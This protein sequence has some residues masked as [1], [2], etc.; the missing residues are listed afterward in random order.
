MRAAARPGFGHSGA[1]DGA[2]IDS[3]ARTDGRR[4]G[5]RADARAR[6]ARGAFCATSVLDVD[7]QAGAATPI[8][9]AAD[10]DYGDCETAS[11]YYLRVVAT[12]GANAGAALTIDKAP[13]G[14]IATGGEA[15]VGGRALNVARGSLALS[16]ATTTAYANAKVYACAPGTIAAGVAN[17]ACAQCSPGTFAATAGSGACAPCAV[18]KFAANAGSNA[19]ADC[20][21]GRFAATAGSNACTLCAVGTFANTT[22]LSACY[23]CPAGQ[24]ANAAGSTACHDCPVGVT[25]TPGSAACDV[26]AASARASTLFA[27]AVVA[28]SAAVPLL[29]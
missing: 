18:G 4:H 9:A 21:A 6:R 13:A 8:D 24:F 2:R 19:C 12:D 15:L 7:G 20:P 10:V 11:G 16:D 23:N 3:R 26:I 28:A 1:R 5:A 22:G 14:W 27:A 29:A 25:S 17:G